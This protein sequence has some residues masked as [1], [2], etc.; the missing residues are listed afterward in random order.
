M[1]INFGLVIVLVTLIHFPSIEGQQSVKPPTPLH[2]V[3]ASKKKD[4]SLAKDAL[5][6]GSKRFV[7][8]AWP[9]Y[10]DPAFDAEN[11]PLYP[12]ASQNEKNIEAFYG[13]KGLNVD[14]TLLSYIK[15]FYFYFEYCVRRQKAAQIL[16]ALGGPTTPAAA[17]S[18]CKPIAKSSYES[19]LAQQGWS[20]LIKAAEEK[21]KAYD[22]VDPNQCAWEEVNAALLKTFEVEKKDAADFW[23][24]LTQTSFWKDITITNDDLNNSIFWQTWIKILINNT[25]NI[26]GVSTSSKKA[27][28]EQIF[29]YL[30]HIETAYYADEFTARR[31]R[32]EL[33]ELTL[34]LNQ[35]VRERLLS[36]STT[37]NIKTPGSDTYD[38]KSIVQQ[39]GTLYGE[40]FYTLYQNVS[41]P[42]FWGE[43][44][45]PFTKT[46]DGF[47]LRKI[48]S[49]EPH[50][51]M[52]LFMSMA[53]SLQAFLQN[54]LFDAAHL[55][56]TASALQKN[57][58]PPMPSILPF[59]LDDTP[60]LDDINSISYA[61]TQMI[62]KK[63]TSQGTPS[64]VTKVATGPD[65]EAVSPQGF[66]DWI[67]DAG[68][69][70][71]KD[72]E[73]LAKT[74]FATVKDVVKTLD[75]EA[76]VFYYQSG[77]ATMLT[78]IPPAKAAKL[79]KAYKAAAEGDLT[80]FSKDVNTLIKNSIIL[81]NEPT[82]L[83]IEAIGTILHDPNLANDYEGMLDSIADA[84]ATTI[85]ASI[86]E[87]GE[88]ATRLGT[89][90]IAL[91]AGTVIELGTG[92]VK[93]WEDQ[94]KMIAYDTAT[95]F[96]ETITID[97]GA[98]KELIKDLIQGVGYLIKMLTDAIIDVGAVVATVLDPNV[99]ENPSSFGRYY[100]QFHNTLEA[101]QMLISSLV[102]VGLMVGVF[103][104]T[105]PF[106]GGV[107][108]AALFAGGLGLTL[109]FGGMM[110]ASGVQSDKEIADVKKEVQRYLDHFTV[111]TGNQE[112]IGST[113]QQNLTDNIG[114]QLD[115]EIINKQLGL[116]FYENY[117]DG[118]KDRIECQVSMALGG[119][120]N[121]IMQKDAKSGL[122]LGDV[123]SVYGYTTDWLNFNPSQGVALYEPSRKH[124]AQEVAQLP[125]TFTVTEDGQQEEMSRFWF[126]QSLSKDIPW[127]SNQTTTFEIRFK[128]IYL[129]DNY[130]VGLGIGGRPINTTVLKKDNLGDIDRY[131]LTKMLVFNKK[132]KQTTPSIG[133]Y[134]HES[135][136]AK[137]NW[138][139]QTVSGPKTFTPGV[140]YHMR[141][142][143]SPKDISVQVWE[144]GK[145]KPAATKVA[146]TPLPATDDYNWADCPPSKAEKPE[147]ITS[148]PVSII[149]SGASIEFDIVTPSQKDNLKPTDY[150]PLKTAT[151]MER[152]EGSHTSY[153]NVI[154]PTLG[155]IKLTAADPFEIIKG[156]FIYK[157]S[158]TGIADYVVLANIGSDNEPSKNGI[159]VSIENKTTPPNA[160]M[161]LVSGNIMDKNKKILG[162]VANLLNVYVQQNKTSDSFINQ[163]LLSEIE[164]AQK[165]YIKRQAQPF[166]LGIFTLAGNADALSKGQFV[167]KT[168]INK[169]T[170]YVLLAEISS[171]GDVTSFGLP[172]DPANK[173]INGILSLVS[174]KAY[175]IKSPKPVRSLTK[176]I[177]ASYQA[178][179][180]DL[181]E[182]LLTSISTAQAAYN[183]AATET[184]PSQKTS[185]SSGAPSSNPNSISTNQGTHKPPK[186]PPPSNQSS[187]SLNQQ[188]NQAGAPSGW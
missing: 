102:T 8:A 187:S 33:I 88:W 81:A 31:Y 173:K 68:K 100:E 86:H 175:S 16:M 39:T 160:V 76:H 123:G 32:T 58:H 129:L 29:S 97:L 82:A 27:T 90:S 110:I 34:V 72:I 9:E 85:S 120:Q 149:Y 57:D 54:D 48:S 125:S 174:F 96:L 133:V 136:I 79:A 98:I 151:E 170:H 46:A 166:K 42:Q 2:T 132:S 17:N 113:M 156:H 178:S 131:Y 50:R 65:N 130:Y 188:Q 75:D 139:T 71:G 109:A 177:L 77:L 176:T 107:V 44:G 93:G 26:D 38:F 122:V 53:A 24:D 95:A 159:G 18:T 47:K 41:N 128:P 69:K 14:A 66:T 157:T 80:N 179:N 4:N 52:L 155:T 1:K 59:D 101:H 12:T 140:W 163:S 182:S 108:S 64:S 56:A 181:P 144:E 162:T 23:K 10:P 55:Q 78:H 22:T 28:A 15:S 152:E 184:A 62:P 105:T 63:S 92:N 49:P 148:I 60:Y 99:W 111:W 154:A 21:N 150:P 91:I 183:K 51:H 40:E 84:I 127:T 142:T 19:I 36:Q 169:L 153:Q 70:I 119:Y 67:E 147:A 115:A 35:N 138:L 89:D 126:L 117:F 137:D 145:S 11:P 135:T 124:F 114:A 116:G 172:Y 185:P 7:F 112:V 73:G 83:T 87:A 143:L 13:A 74:A 104:L 106:T 61:I 94:W 45:S 171:N 30:P 146:V 168:T 103:V 161:S 118:I 141:A 43:E 121:Q 158:D 134:E 164:A 3:I 37:L 25:I 180:G 5:S 186:L 6:E 20:G 165:Q 167:F